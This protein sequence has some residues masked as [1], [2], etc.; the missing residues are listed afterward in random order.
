L[1]SKASELTRPVR[2][3][4]VLDGHDGDGAEIVV[5]AGDHPGVAAPGA[6]QSGKAELEWLADATGALGQ[7]PVDELDRCG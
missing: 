6:M 1:P 2:V 5:D 7:G 4:A 3:G